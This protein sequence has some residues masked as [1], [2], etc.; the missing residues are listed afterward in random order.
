MAAVSLC[1]GLRIAFHCGPASRENGP[2]LVPGK[3]TYICE[4]CP[5]SPAS[6]D[7]HP[8][9]L[10]EPAPPCRWM[11]ASANPWVINPRSGENLHEPR[12]DGGRADQ[13]RRTRLRHFFSPLERA[14]HLPDRT[15]RGWHV[16]A[17]RRAI[18]VS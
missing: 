17:G 6:R 7:D 11:F 8:P 13:P 15:G 3:L 14:H 1:G 2:G 10:F 5:F 4:P 16:D 18:V 12:A 9:R